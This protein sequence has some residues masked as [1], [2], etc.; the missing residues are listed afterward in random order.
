MSA[1]AVS[2]HELH[3]SRG[4]DHHREFLKQER[5][6][7]RQRVAHL[8]KAIE[9][10]DWRRVYD[11]MT[12]DMFPWAMA[13]SQLAKLQDVPAEIQETFQSAWIET[14]TVPAQVNNHRLVCAALRV[15]L[16][17]YTGPAVR[18]FRG[19]GF[20]EHRKRQYSLS[21]TEDYAT[22]ERFARDYSVMHSGSVILETVAPPA[23][24][25]AKVKYPEPYTEA[26]REEMRLG[27]IRFDE[28]HEEREFLVDRRG[29]GVG[30]VTVVQR[31]A[32]SEASTPR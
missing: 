27:N 5:K 21:W 10:N 19:A 20:N 22:A 15:M 14:K 31:F 25:I 13:L 17:P 9:R 2:H 30:A 7:N 1:N 11:N 24:I 4:R 18:L 12:A 8:M 29:L 26:E 3:H 16:P 32:P 28:Y 6:Q 23:A